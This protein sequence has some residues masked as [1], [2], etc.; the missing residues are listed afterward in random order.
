MFFHPNLPAAFSRE[1]TLLLPRAKCPR[2]PLLVNGEK[3][4]S[5]QLLLGPLGQPELLFFA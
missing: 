5:V 4:G 1:A 3:P 2:R